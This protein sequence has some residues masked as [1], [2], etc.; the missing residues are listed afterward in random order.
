M[1]QA[2]VQPSCGWAWTDIGTSILDPIST[3][4]WRDLVLVG[5]DIEERHDRSVVES[6]LIGE[7]V[8]PPWSCL[9]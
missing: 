8:S 4:M 6:T 9:R 5:V 1:R 3:P 2:G 7:G